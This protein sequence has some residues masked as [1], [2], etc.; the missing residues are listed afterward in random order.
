M[1]ATE[2]VWICARSMGRDGNPVKFHVSSI[3]TRSVMIVKTSSVECFNFFMKPY[4]TPRQ[5]RRAISHTFLLKAQTHECKST[6]LC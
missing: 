2:N 1:A 6:E 5:K 4:L 3:S